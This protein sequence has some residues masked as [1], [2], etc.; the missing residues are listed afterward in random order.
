MTIQ[1]IDLRRPGA[2]LFVVLL[3][4]GFIAILLHSTFKD[5]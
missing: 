3:H 4:V 5:A 1:T 2:A